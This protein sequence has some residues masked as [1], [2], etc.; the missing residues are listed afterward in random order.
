MNDR[1]IS[2]RQAAFGGFCMC[3]RPLYAQASMAGAPAVARL[4][5]VAPG[6]HIRQGLVEDATAANS[7]AI[8]NIGFIVGRDAVAVIDP[9]GSFNDGQSLL[10][11]I[12]QVTELPIRY[13]VQSHVHPDH[14]FGAAAFQAEKSVFV[15][16]FNLPQ[17]FEARGSYYQQGL[18]KI[19]GV[20][21]AG[22]LITPSLL[23]R[24]QVEIDL[25]GRSLTLTAHPTAHTN[26]D[27][28][29]VDRRTNVL[30]AGD[31]LFVNRVPSIDGDIRGWLSQLA[32]LSI[33][34][35]KAAVPGHGPALVEWP[36]A[37]RSLQRYLTVLLD[38]TRAAIDHGMPI[39]EAV[40]TVGLSER[41][42][43]ALFDDYN[44][45]NVIEA[46]RRLEWE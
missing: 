14:V 3:C 38:E 6:I 41:G 39:E 13:V 12:R 43:W 2:R 22:R 11:A 31:L 46:Y 28:S 10:L 24:D 8:A 19:L 1:M 37:V 33:L 21:R 40:T 35:V 4:A 42:N 27:L 23:V 15:G 25:G 44:G 26:C 16:H 34:E 5:E 36:D 29:V 17:A 32:A 18:E 7:D 20:G 9:G 45:R 30:L